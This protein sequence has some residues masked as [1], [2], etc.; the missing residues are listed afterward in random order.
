VIVQ[1]GEVVYLLQALAC[2]QVSDIFGVVVHRHADG[3]LYTV[4]GQG[5]HHLL[6]AVD[7]LLSLAG[8][9]AV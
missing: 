4:A 5:P 1:H 6:V 2:G 9:H 7:T 8:F 3:R